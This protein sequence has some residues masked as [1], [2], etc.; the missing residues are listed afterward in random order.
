MQTR[1]STVAGSSRPSRG[2]LQHIISWMNRAENA[3]TD[4]AFSVLAVGAPPSAGRTGE[5]F[6]VLGGDTS[7]RELCHASHVRTS[8]A[9]SIGLTGSCCISTSSCRAFFG[10]P[11]RRKL[12]RRERYLKYEIPRCPL[13]VLPC[14][15]N[16]QKRSN[17]ER[18]QSPSLPRPPM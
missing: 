13:C 12:S 8:G 18:E 1:V 5:V 17:T 14:V 2:R 10:G 9:S 7:F 11:R 6:L 15:V 4:K 3:W 16:V